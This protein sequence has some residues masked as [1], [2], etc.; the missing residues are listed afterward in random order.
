MRSVHGETYDYSKFVY[1]TLR[2]KGEIVCREHGSFFQNYGNHFFNRSGCPKC[3]HQRVMQQQIEV[4][5][6]P[7]NKLTLDAV[8]NRMR[9]THSTIFDYTAFEYVEMKTP[10]KILCPTHGSFWMSPNDHVRSKTG[11]PECSIERVRATNT[12]SLDEV[13]ARA[14]QVHG[15][16][17]EYPS[18][19]YVNS[20]TPFTIICHVHGAFQQRYDTHIHQMSGCPKCY[21]SFK[22]TFDEFVID[23]KNVHGERYDY[24]EVTYV[25]NSTPVKIMCFSH[26]SFW[27][28]PFK[29]INVGQGCMRCADNVSKVERKWLNAIGIPDDSEHRQVRIV[30]SQMRADGMV[31][32]VV[33]E[34]FGT[35]WH[36]D[37][38]KHA[39][40]TL[41]TKNGHRMGSL[42]LEAL[43]QQRRILELGYE[44]KF[45]WELDYRAG[46][47]FSEKNPHE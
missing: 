25:N 5:R 36:G 19:V 43:E 39:P 6:S 2:I 41:N 29:H 47:L 33:Y 40:D 10:G 14:R 30:G 34:F 31:E 27:Q 17:Y 44:L 24:S 16:T 12:P 3:V 8:V 1:T 4:Q 28:R 21:G 23:A 18:Q 7:P 45:V 46:L 20:S 15:D 26:G 13:V 32:R 11:C 35:Y 9:Q 38:R 42:Y 37:P 22:R